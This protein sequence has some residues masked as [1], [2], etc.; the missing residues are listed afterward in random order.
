MRTLIVALLLSVL[1]GACGGDEPG[2]TAVEDPS[3]TPSSVE[4]TT[5]PSPSS[6]STVR[7]QPAKVLIDTGEGS[8]LID[9]EKAETPEQHSLGLMHRTSLPAEAGM[10]FLFFQ[11][12]TGGFWMKNTLIPLSI[13]FFDEKGEIVRILDMEPCR[14]DPC[15]V[16]D[17]GTSYSGALEVNQGAFDRWGVAEGDRITVTH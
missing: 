7:F 8:V 16:Y 1:L 9:A 13:A 12:R 17:P 6:S 3:P 11:E 15:E 5:A 14:A 4:N 2:S 10:V